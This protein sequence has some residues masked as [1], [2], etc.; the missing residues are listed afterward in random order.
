MY[1][2]KFAPL[3]SRIDIT[4]N[5]TVADDIHKAY[6][7]DGLDITAALKGHIK[8][9]AVQPSLKLH[10]SAEW[11]YTGLSSHFYLLLYRML[12]VPL[13]QHHPVPP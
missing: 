8:S 4:L 10:L 7:Y 9:P 12:P 2:T 1:S 11:F 13:Q 3:W 6:V 5:I